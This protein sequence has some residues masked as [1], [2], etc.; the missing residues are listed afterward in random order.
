[1]ESAFRT[2]SIYDRVVIQ[3]VQL[4]EKSLAEEF[5][6]SLKT[7]NRSIRTINRYI[8]PKRLR[9]NAS[10]CYEVIVLT[11]DEMFK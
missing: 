11:E 6:V 8:Y 3:G 7:I 9:T 10:K 2:L 4:T 5:E 1:M